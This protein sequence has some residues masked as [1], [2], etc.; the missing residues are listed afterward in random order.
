VLE[1]GMWRVHGRHLHPQDRE[2]RRK[3]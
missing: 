2:N 3:E 1:K